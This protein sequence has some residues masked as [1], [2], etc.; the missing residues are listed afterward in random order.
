[1][2]YIYVGRIITT[3]GLNGEM[4][5]RSNFKYKD[6]AFKVGNKIY[7]GLAREEHEII[8]YRKHMEYDMLILSN[9]SDIDK[10][11]KYKKELL[12]TTKDNINLL[13][14]DYLDEDLI[15]LTA[16]YNDRKI[17]VIRLITDE[18]NNNLIIRLDNGKCIPKNKHFILKVDLDNKK[19]YFTN[20]EG[21]L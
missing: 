12:Y 9:I 10:A 20:L 2:E 6:Q 19:I 4:K 13:E 8:S 7:I 1:M 18:G 16:I 14:D 21:L 5:I 3:H 11:I 15:G 17:G